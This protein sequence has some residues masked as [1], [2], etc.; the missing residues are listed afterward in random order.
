MPAFPDVVGSGV[1]DRDV[2]R[3]AG[4]DDPH[5]QAVRP[6]LAGGDGVARGGAVGD[7]M[8]PVPATDC[9]VTA[10]MRCPCWATGHDRVDV[11]GPARHMR[12]LMRD[13]VARNAATDVSVVEEVIREARQARTDG[14]RLYAGTMRK[15]TDLVIATPRSSTICQ[16][17]GVQP[18]RVTS[19]KIAG[20]RRPLV[21]QRLPALP[22]HGGRGRRPPP[23]PT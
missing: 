22:D 4:R 1:V 17:A 2:R 9:V 13:A 7:G 5:V 10:T 14:L 19:S 20:D 18:G 6:E 21:E 12:R 8:V 3:G 23:T 11:D 15:A 16:R